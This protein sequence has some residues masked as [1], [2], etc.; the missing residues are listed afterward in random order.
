MVAGAG[1]GGL[2]AAAR[3]RELG[4]TVDV[5]EKGDRPGGSMLLSGGFVWRYRDFETFRTQCPAGDPELQGIV[6]DRLDEDLAWLEGLGAPVLERA[7]GNPLTSGLRF[8]PAGLTETLVE[9]AGEI[10]LGEALT[11]LPLG[12]PVILATGGFQ[13][14]R[15]LVRR[16]ITPEAH[17][18]VLR[19]NP[20]SAGDGL[21]LGLEAGAQA[22][23]GMAEFWG[24]TLAAA[25]EIA[26]TDFR[27]L[28]LT[29][30]RF[31]TVVNAN[32][33]V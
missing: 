22:T 32:G 4:A 21:R 25:P 17:S 8:D 33:D 1:M 24:R 14:D 15:E 30:A 27:A 19:S 10:R 7:T 13:G 3:A 2:V 12:P 26:S 23:A 31:A 28:S 11:R 20:W 5:Y 29:F 16:H 9:R 18:L 6:F